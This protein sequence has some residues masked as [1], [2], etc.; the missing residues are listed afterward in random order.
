[1][2]VGS[3][4]SMFK[5]GATITYGVESFHAGKQAGRLA[6]QILKG[7]KPDVI[8]AEMADY[9]LG[10]NLKTAKASDIEVPNEILIRADYVVAEE[11]R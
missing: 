7:G 9:F 3:S 5:K 1:M 10:I 4:T 6:S 11:T 8:P 2:P